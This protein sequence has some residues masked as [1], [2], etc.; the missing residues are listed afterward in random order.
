V[1]GGNMVHFAIPKHRNGYQEMLRKLEYVLMEC[2][3]KYIDMHGK[4]PKDLIV[5]FKGKILLEKICKDYLYAMSIYSIGEYGFIKTWN[6]INVIFNPK[7][8]TEFS[9]DEKEDLKID[10][11]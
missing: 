4:Q 1:G 11:I 6:N 9:F 3:Q 7:Q 10:F 8:N 2:T 5:N